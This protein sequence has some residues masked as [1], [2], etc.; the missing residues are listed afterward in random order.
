MSR[1]SSTSTSTNTERAGGVSTGIVDAQKEYEL[2]LGRAVDTLKKDYPDLLYHHPSW[3]LYHDDLEVIDPSGVS[4]H[5][6]ENYKMA[7][8]FIHAVVKVFYC[9]E[10]SSVTSVRVAYDCARKCIR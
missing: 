9:E 2:N 10:K 5:G 8:G 7:F 1:T 3:N 4:L 6:L